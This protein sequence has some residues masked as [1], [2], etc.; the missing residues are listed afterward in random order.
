MPRDATKYAG[1]HTSALGGLFIA[2]EWERMQGE[3]Y[4]FDSDSGALGFVKH[5]PPQNAVGAGLISLAALFEPG[6]DVGVESHGN[7]LFQGP[8]KLA[9]HS[10]LPCV[11]RK[12]WDVGGIDRIVGHGGEGS[13]LALLSGGQRLAGCSLPSYLYFRFSSC[14]GHRF[15]VPRESPSERK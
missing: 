1:G 11:T 7:G 14:L 8:I 10:I 2:E 6:D 3:V 4:K 12:F 13:E 15:S 9:A 5:M